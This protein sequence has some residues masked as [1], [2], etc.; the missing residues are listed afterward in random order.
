MGLST[1]G[2]QLQSVYLA[3]SGR[4]PPLTTKTHIFAGCLDY[5]W[6]SAGNWAVTALLDL[7]YPDGSGPDPSTVEIGMMPDELFPSDHLA[8]G[9]DLRL[10]RIKESG[11]CGFRRFM[12][13]CACSNPRRWYVGGN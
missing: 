1:A 7:P 11:F 9:A 2:L 12:M 13:Y 8:I 4:E 3:F 5:L 10:Q 6:C